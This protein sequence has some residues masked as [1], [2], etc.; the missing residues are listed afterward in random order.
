MKMKDLLQLHLMALMEEVIP[1]FLYL[2][3][4]VTSIKIILYLIQEDC[5]DIRLFQ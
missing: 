2:G 3:W 4:E 5:P 1:D